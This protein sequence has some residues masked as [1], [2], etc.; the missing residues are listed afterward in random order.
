MYFN[1]LNLLL[2]S[3]VSSKKS[4]SHIKTIFKSSQLNASMKNVC[5]STTTVLSE[6][7]QP[8]WKIYYKLEPRKGKCAECMTLVR[9][10]KRKMSYRI[11]EFD[12]TETEYFCCD[13]WLRNKGSVGGCSIPKCGENILGKCQ[14]GGR[15]HESK[16]RCVCPKG[17]GGNTCNRDKNECKNYKK[18]SLCDQKCVNLLG[19]YKCECNKGYQKHPTD[20]KTCVDINECHTPKRSGCDHICTNLLGSFKCSCKKGFELQNDGLSCKLSEQFDP[21]EI[22]NGDCDHFCS[23]NGT[24]R[25]CDCDKGFRLHPMTK[26]TCHQFDPCDDLICLNDSTCTTFEEKSTGM[27]Q[28]YCHC[29]EGWS[30]DFC[31]EDVDECSGNTVVET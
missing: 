17:W 26:S 13:G 21:C 2:F 4:N 19:G 15:C 30:G 6:R 7:K 20:M 5:S 24:E 22:N 18:G 11:V 3:T 12:K 14:N 23:K 16:S 8:C 29:G 10:K 31:G 9:V 25:V 1:L 28:S 27:L